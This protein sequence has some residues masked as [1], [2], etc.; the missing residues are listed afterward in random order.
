MGYSLLHC[1]SWLGAGLAGGHDPLLHRGF[2]RLRNPACTTY[3]HRPPACLPSLCC[4]CCCHCFR[5]VDVAQLLRMSLRRAIMVL[6]ARATASS[7]ILAAVRLTSLFSLS[8]TAFCCGFVASFWC[9]FEASVL[10][11]RVCVVALLS[12]LDL[13]FSLRS[14]PATSRVFD[15]LDCS[16][17]SGFFRGGLSCFF[18]LWYSDAH[19]LRCSIQAEFD[20][21]AFVPGI[22]TSMQQK[23]DDNKNQKAKRQLPASDTACLP[24]CQ[25]L[26]SIGLVVTC[27]SPIADPTLQSN[28]A[29]ILAR[30][31]A[32]YNLFKIACVG[33]S[34]NC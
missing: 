14:S 7:F 8:R 10:R 18:W 21:P 31:R 29:I 13:A 9:A 12:C 1:G 28:D 32:F 19:S 4:H 25:R 30:A 22:F 20:E 6:C 11:F 24:K 15:A 16:F 17:L 26:V 27:N 34:C 5:L 33:P 2:V 23:F 3:L